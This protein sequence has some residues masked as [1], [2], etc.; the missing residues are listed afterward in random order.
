MVV[1]LKIVGIVNDFDDATLIE[2]IVKVFLIE[3]R[4]NSLFSLNKK[5]NLDNPNQKLDEFF[6]N[7]LEF[8]ENSNRKLLRI[9]NIDDSKPVFNVR[10]LF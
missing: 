9:K 8:K 3:N 2:D 5:K 6:E 1:G 7:D 4:I 10:G